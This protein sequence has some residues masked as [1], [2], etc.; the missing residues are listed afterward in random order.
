MT[1]SR[2]K[3]DHDVRRLLSDAEKSIR[4][5][6]IICNRVVSTSKKQGNTEDEHDRLVRRRATEMVKELNNL[7]LHMSKV[8]RVTPLFGSDDH[9]NT[10]VKPR[11]KPVAPIVRG[12]ATVRNDSSF[13]V[14][15]ESGRFVSSDQLNSLGDGDDE[16]Q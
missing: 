10:G 7:L 16:D 14:R 13:S 8:S 4:S 5:A 3:E 2:S 11:D 6:A 15:S 1:L 9:V 12:V